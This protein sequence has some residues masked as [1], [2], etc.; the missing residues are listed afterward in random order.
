MSDM[1]S[2]DGEPAQVPDEIVVRDFVEFHHLTYMSVLRV[3]RC[4][5]DLDADTAY[6]A[7]QEAYTAMWQNWDNRCDRPLSEN[8]AYAMRIVRNKIVDYYRKNRRSIV[9]QDDHDM[10]A[11]DST[12][13]TV[14][15]K[16]TLLSAVVRFLESQPPKRRAV[17]KL[18]FL[19]EYEY[20]EIAELL[21]M[22]ESTVRTHVGRARE[23][24]K[25]FVAQMMQ[26]NRGGEGAC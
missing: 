24:L 17:A 23:L 20:S 22:S 14:L 18:R 11:P 2:G 26:I 9:L 19:G 16:L 8:R 6:D 15:D 25:P 7:T 13:D 12:L 3:A 5:P 21:G 10:C 1:P 4:V